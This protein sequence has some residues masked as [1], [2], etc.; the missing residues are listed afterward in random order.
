M[1]SFST[2]AIAAVNPTA[3]TAPNPMQPLFLSNSM[4][5]PMFR[6]ST[7]FLDP[8]FKCSSLYLPKAHKFRHLQENIDD[9]DKD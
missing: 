5:Q 1:T 2:A 6:Q 3:I 9:K 7:A 4:Q 8:S